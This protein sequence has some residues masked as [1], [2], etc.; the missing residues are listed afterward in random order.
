[1]SQLQIHSLFLVQRAVSISCLLLAPMCST[2]SV[3]DAGGTLQEEGA[4]S[5]C[6]HAS[7]RLFFQPGWGE[8]HPVALGP[9]NRSRALSPLASL[10]PQPSPVT[11]HHLPLATVP[12]SA[13]NIPP[14]S[15]LPNVGNLCFLCCL[16]NLLVE[17]YRSTMCL[18][19]K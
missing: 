19:R 13:F 16:I 15:I 1:M 11:P 5:W 6:Q 12:T 10:Q 7:V 14:P 9:S 8:G 4:S 17:L 18:F 3:E 2:L